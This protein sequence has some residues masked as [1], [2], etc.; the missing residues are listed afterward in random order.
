MV[1]VDASIALVH[2]LSAGNEVVIARFKATH[3]APNEPNPRDL[4]DHPPHQLA[5]ALHR[6]GKDALIGK[7][8]G[9]AQRTIRDRG[10]SNAG[11]ASVESGL[12]TITV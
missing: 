8:C 10:V 6:R 11:L 2:C 4:R 3:V 7:Q 12:A 1:T 9:D 5:P